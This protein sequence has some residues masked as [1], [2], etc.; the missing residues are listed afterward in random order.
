MEFCPTC[1]NMLQYELPHMGRPSRFFC[2]TCPYVCHIETKVKIKKKQRLVKKELEP[3]I[4]EDDMK[5]A[6]HTDATCPRCGHG[7]A[8]YVQFQTRSADEPATT[9]YTC[10]NETC[11]IKWRDD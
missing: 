10:L 5:N 7:R 11:R 2:P 9:F 1:G 3:V 6:S 8:A 4:T